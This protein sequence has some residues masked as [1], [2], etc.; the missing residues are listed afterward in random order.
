MYL[1]LCCITAC[2]CI[3]KLPR[4][5]TPSASPNPLDYA[6]QVYL[7]IRSNTASKCITKLARS[8]HRRVS[9]SSLDRNF[10][11]HLELLSSFAC[12]L[13]RYTVPRWVAISIHRWEYN[14]NS[15]D[16]KIIK[17]WVIAMISRY[18]CNIPKDV[19]LPR[20]LYSDSRCFQ[21]C[22]CRSQ[23][24]PQRFLGAPTHVVGTPRHV[25]HAPRWSQTYHN[26]FH[27]TP[28]P[29][30]RNPSASESR[31][32]CTPRVWYSPE[33]D[34]FKFTF[35][36]LSDTPGVIQRLKYILLMSASHC[37]PK[38]TWFRP[39]SASLCTLD[40]NHPVLLQ[41]CSIM[42]SKY[43]SEFTCSNSPSQSPN[44][45]YHGIPVHTILA[46][47]RI[48]KLTW[49]W[50]PCASQQSLDYDLPVYFHTCLNTASKCISDFPQSQTHSTSPNS[51]NHIL[52]GCMIM[53]S[54]FI[55]RP[56]RFWHPNSSPSPLRHSFPVI[57]QTRLNIAQMWSTTFTHSLPPGLSLSSHDHHLQ[58]HHE[59][60]SSTPC[61]QF[62]YTGCRCVAL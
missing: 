59:L 18:T 56:G 46:S 22:C 33:I 23:A 4:L 3:S 54:K 31:L 38:I 53:S 17:Q 51:L 55:S 62:T 14:L 34:T 11:A 48:S 1:Q 2:K 26:H 16:L 60:L 44:L 9:L 49:L 8:Q 24:G 12:S 21:A 7:S 13:S 42:A 19:I 43:I 45:L 32:E 58:T 35:H 29:V 27:G 41:T 20:L 47:K 61:S 30:I 5:Q 52:Q 28:V 50:P 36:I 57:L 40:Q 37:L 10:Q 25:A 15:S 39:P 6:L